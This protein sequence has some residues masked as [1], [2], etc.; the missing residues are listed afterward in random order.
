M[1]KEPWPRVLLAD[2]EPDILQVVLLLVEDLYPQAEVRTARDG[3]QAMRHLA[4][5]RP[6]LLI[7]DF[8]MPEYDGLDL[9]R[10]I[11]ADHNLEDTKVLGLSA[12]ATRRD[13]AAFFRNGAAE[14]IRKPFDSHTLKMTVRRM[15]GERP[16]T[17]SV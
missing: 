17:A 7:T 11:A 8:R 10:R 14:F 12:Y 15:L 16:L 6:H 4:S 9:C 1:K 5:F 3:E 2:D 13:M